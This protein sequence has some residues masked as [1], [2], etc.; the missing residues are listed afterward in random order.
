MD[1]PLFPIHLGE[2]LLEDFKKPLGLTKFRLVYDFGVPP[3]RISHIVNCRR[4]ISA[5]KAMR[6]AHYFET[7]AEVW[8]C[9]HV[10]MIWTLPKSS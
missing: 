5:D 3:I 4:A 7:S 1:N 8:L 6:L 2:V 10:F 9:M